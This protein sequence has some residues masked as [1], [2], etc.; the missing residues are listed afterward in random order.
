M[1]SMQFL[2]IDVFP[3]VFSFVIGVSTSRNLFIMLNFIIL[4]ILALGRVNSNNS[5]GSLNPDA[6]I[7]YSAD[8]EFTSSSSHESEIEAQGPQSAHVLAADPNPSAMEG[9]LFK[10]N[11]S[12]DS[13]DDLRI[14]E[15]TEVYL[16]LNDVR[17]TADVAPFCA[18]SSLHSRGKINPQQDNGDDDYA[19]FY[20]CEMNDTTGEEG[21]INSILS[22]AMNDNPSS[23]KNRDQPVR[24]AQTNDINVPLAK[25]RKMKHKEKQNAHK[26]SSKSLSDQLINRSHGEKGSASTEACEGRSLTTSRFNRRI[27]SVSTT[28][29]DRCSS[30]LQFSKPILRRGDTL[31]ATWKAIC[32]SKRQMSP[33]NRHRDPKRLSSP[34]QRSQNSRC[35]AAG[36][37]EA[38]DER[39]S[40]RTKGLY[41]VSPSPLSPMKQRC[42]SRVRGVVPY[43]YNE[44]PQPTT[45]PIESKRDDSMDR[46]QLNAEVESFISKF[47]AR[48]RVQREK[49]LRDY[50]ERVGK[51]ANS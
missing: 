39:L 45:T 16:E 3:R 11:E 41:S 10:S 48:I 49:S 2:W 27:K 30:P 5:S 23:I 42:K 34:L 14:R 51:G 25:A 36:G 26:K 12:D 15:P 22:A 6:Y 18:F 44:D 7:R 17:R 8:G 46:D 28:T 40:R 33:F 19:E 24:L 43:D 21:N 29:S 9:I 13:Q 1:V 31:D 38:M 47:Y 37:E 35:I 32:E 4:T 20:D 50:L